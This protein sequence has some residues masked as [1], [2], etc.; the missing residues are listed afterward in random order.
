MQIK[1]QPQVSGNLPSK[2]L[3]PVVCVL[4][5]FVSDYDNVYKTR[6]VKKKACLKNI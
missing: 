5:S 6:K 4:L 3:S 2:Q 1:I